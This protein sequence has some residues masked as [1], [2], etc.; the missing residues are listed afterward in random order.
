MR[1]TL[2]NK[3]AQENSVGTAIMRTGEVRAVL[4]SWGEWL[5]IETVDGAGYLWI[6]DDAT[7]FKR[8]GKCLGATISNHITNPQG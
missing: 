6:K 2:L 3:P 4:Y 5:A 7:Q 1:L 8:L